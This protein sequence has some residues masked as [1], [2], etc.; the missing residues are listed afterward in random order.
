MK[1]II[2]SSWRGLESQAR[3]HQ[4]PQQNSCPA[5]SEGYLPSRGHRRLCSH[6]CSHG[7]LACCSQ[8]YTS[9]VALPMLGTQSGCSCPHHQRILCLPAS[10]CP[11]PLVQTHASIWSCKA[12]VTWSWLYYKGNS[13]NQDL[14]SLVL[15]MV[16]GFWLPQEPYSR[17][18]ITLETVTWGSSDEE[19][20]RMTDLGYRH[21]IPL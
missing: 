15:I 3:H 14:V 6:H 13:E 7:I 2:S 8:Q 12:Q 4:I 9:T 10:W 20:K 18:C 11:Q 21:L 17:E 16:G 1:R 5:P 19:L